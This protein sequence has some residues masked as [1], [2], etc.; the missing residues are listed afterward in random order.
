MVACGGTR[1]ALHHLIPLYF[2]PFSFFFFSFHRCVK[3]LLRADREA[4][5]Y[6]QLL[7]L[8]QTC[9]G[10]GNLGQLVRV[11]SY[12]K[13]AS[14]RHRPPSS[15]GTYYTPTRLR[16]PFWCD[17]DYTQILFR[18]IHISLAL[19]LF[20]VSHHLPKKCLG[21]GPLSRGHIIIRPGRQQ[22]SPSNSPN[23][24]TNTIRIQ[25]HPNS[26]R[27]ISKYIP[28]VKHDYMIDDA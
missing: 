9:K 24:R 5:P 15:T 13:L 7:L 26:A 2:P 20:F 19:F 17:C 22:N 25:T 14:T 27:C 16:T 10:D 23:K 12:I 6:T 4:I 3:G 21:L 8:R 11:N 28:Y 1:R 18:L